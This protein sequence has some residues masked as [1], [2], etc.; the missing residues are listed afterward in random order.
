MKKNHIA[1]ILHSYATRMK[2]KVLEAYL[3]IFRLHALSDRPKP[4]SLGR[5]K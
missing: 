5:H 2:K 3:P 1:K 4:K